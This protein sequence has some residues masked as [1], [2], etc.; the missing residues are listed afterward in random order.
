MSTGTLNRDVA[1]NFTT[2]DKG[3]RVRV[4]YPKGFPGCKIERIGTL[5]LNAIDVMFC[6]PLEAVTLDEKEEA[7]KP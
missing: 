4:S 6:A 3:T 1:G 5:G 2:W 7:P